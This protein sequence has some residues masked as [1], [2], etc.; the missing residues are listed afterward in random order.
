LQPPSPAPRSFSWCFPPASRKGDRL[1]VTVVIPG[2]LIN[3]T[4]L[5]M[6]VTPALFY[7][8]GP[9][10]RRKNRSPVKKSICAT[11]WKPCMRRQIKPFGESS[12][13]VSA[14][15]RRIQRLSI[16]LN[17]LS[18]PAQADSLNTAHADVCTRELHR[19]YSQF[20]KCVIYPC[21]ASCENCFQCGREV[22]DDHRSRI[23]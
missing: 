9:P 8:L 14:L 16:R 4:P 5:D 12:L 19:G 15:G 7:K 21:K 22:Q 11:S 20:W 17:N 10:R 3:S 6:A 23:L 13:P 18:R 2:G 1:P